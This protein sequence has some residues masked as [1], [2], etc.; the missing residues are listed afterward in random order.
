MPK[1]TKKIIYHEKLKKTL[2]NYF[3]KLNS[4]HREGHFG[5]ESGVGGG[6]LSSVFHNL[7][8]KGK[9]LLERCPEEVPLELSATC[10]LNIEA[11][12]STNGGKPTDAG[13]LAEVL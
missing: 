5:I 3:Y 8:L 12:L 7:G 11:E 2:K 9:D 1:V 10:L 6:G 4:T 13:I